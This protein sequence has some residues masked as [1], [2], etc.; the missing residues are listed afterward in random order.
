[1][2]TKQYLEDESG[3][4]L[5]YIN[6]SYP[7]FENGILKKSANPFYEKLAESY[8]SFAKN[9]L[10]SRAETE[11][12]KKGFQPFSAVMKYETTRENERIK[13]T[14]HTFVFDG[15]DRRDGRTVHQYWDEKTGL[16]NIK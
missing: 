8:V 14:I 7:V 10:L 6:V 1:M 13:V 4:K 11:K 9:K 12:S 15:S 3:K 2:Q 5:I 16:I